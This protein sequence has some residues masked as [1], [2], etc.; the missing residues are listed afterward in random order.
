MN[1]Q[2]N[3]SRIKS[4]MGVIKELSETTDDVVGKE[5][6]FEYHCFESPKSCDAELWY[7]THNKVLVLSIVE[8]G[9]GD[10]KLERL[11]E[12]CPRVYR[13]VFE[14][15]F[16]YAVF[17][18]ELMESKEEFERPD[19]P[20]RNQQESIRRI[21][22]EERNISNFLRRR[23]DMLDYEVERGLNGPF[24]GANICIFFKSEED[25]FESVMEN[26]IDAMY[27]NYFSHIDD[28]SGEWANEYLDMVYYIRN[29]YKDK[30]MKHY[31]DNCG[32][33]SIPLQESIR[34]I[35]REE[36]NEVRVPRSERVELYKDDNIIVV[37]PLT[38]RALQKYAH[39]CQWC[40]NDDKGEWEDYHKGLHAVIIQRNS[41]KPKVGIT[42]HP[43]ASEIFLLAKWDNNQS[44]FE[45]ICQ[46]LEY[47]FRNDRTMSDYYVTISNDINNFATNIVYYSPET[48]IYDQEDN[49]LWNFNIEINDIP[50]VKP[51][52][53]EIMDDY[54][55]EEE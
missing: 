44:S 1:L 10:T 18:D 22:K 39:Q 19:A 34:R 49:F 45:D 2:E 31:D 37:V 11:L 25:F 41:K 53:I 33:G 35:L 47:E 42:G 23:L 50:N 13:V 40:I 32:S 26:A 7:R 5:F 15:G 8:L 30:I 28:N 16:E 48:G 55:T 24:G 9:C 52:V 4:M 38:H 54:L 36:L 6:W 21:L 14:D 27:Y 17:E 29:K 51:K 20:K 43:T 46:M 3:I 12:G